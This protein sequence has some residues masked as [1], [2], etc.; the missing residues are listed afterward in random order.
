MI[1]HTYE[2]HHLQRSKL[3]STILP[4][5]LSNQLAPSWH[6]SHRPKHIY[7]I[8]ALSVSPPARGSRPSR[9]KLP[10]SNLL[11]ST[12][13]YRHTSGGQGMGR[14]G[15]WHDCG[16]HKIDFFPLMATLGW[17]SSCESWLRFLLSI[18]R[19]YLQ[20]TPYYSA[21]WFVCVL[22]RKKEYCPREAWSFGDQWW[23]C[24][25]KVV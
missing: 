24:T 19:I 11:R 17:C 13:S 4:A 5:L 12:F 8:P 20:E 14:L 21:S 3:L 6:Q 9:Y 7:N 25:G 10:P 16:S 18:R 2:P 22:I 23:K 15:L 1:I